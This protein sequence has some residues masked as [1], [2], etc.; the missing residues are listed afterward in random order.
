MGT[1][2]FERSTAKGVKGAQ[3][4]KRA[5][6]STATVFTGLLV[7]AICAQPQGYTVSARP[8]AVNF[9]EGHA[10]LNGSPVSDKSLR[11]TFVNAK[12]ILST[13]IGKAEIL[14]TPGVFLRIGDNSR[15]RMVSPSLT[16]TQV[17]IMDGEAMIEADGL[18]KDNNLTIVD[19]GASIRIAKDGLYR[20]TA[21]DNPAAAVLEGKAQINLNDKKA[22]IGKGHEVLLADNLTP[23]KFNTKATD[24]LYAWSNVRSGYDAATSYQSAKNVPISGYDGGTY[25]YSPWSSLGFN[26]GYGPGWY[27]NSAFSGYGWL[28]GSGAFF[29][30]FGYGFYGFNYL[31]YAPV[32]AVP[33]KGLLAGGGTPTGIGTTNRTTDVPVNPNHPPATGLTAAASPAINQ[34]ARSVIAH[35][36]AGTGFRTG[37]GFPAAGFAGG[38]MVSPSAG[39]AFA[40]ESGTAAG[41]HGA[42]A[43]APSFGGGHASGGGHR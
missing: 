41:V 8:G 31:P 17:E 19:H 32:V 24:D 11:N 18:L 25:T 7:T 26:S 4:M 1:S 30:P 35:S 21:D 5:W 20:F 10:Y 34:A 16:D 13:D 39:S 9:I 38:H 27:W 29:S 6:H 22:D 43:A 23:Q 3:N 33:T 42:A 28:P 36:Y 12:D 40:H 2:Y 15:I 14:L 37:A